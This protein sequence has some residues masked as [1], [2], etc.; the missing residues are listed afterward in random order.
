MG[1]ASLDIPDVKLITP[2]VFGDDRGY[3]VET[4]SRRTLEAAGIVE[5]WV[6]DNQSLS[7]HVGTVRGLHYQMPPFAQAKLIRVL[8]G[9]IMDV[10]VDLRRR[11][12]SFG[13]FVTAN[14]SADSFEQIYIPAGFAHGFCTLEPDT[15][16]AYKASAFYAPQYD[17]AV[18]WNDP[19]LNIPWPEDAKA[20][21]SPKDE[22]APFLSAVTD[23][24]DI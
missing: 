18:R 21:L 7:R 13:K 16:V 8:H 4:F 15:I 24:F 14:L 10:A 9:R 3:L 17:R 12:P 2:E 19:S 22:T 6:Q 5:D 11:S 20:L 23:L 1:V